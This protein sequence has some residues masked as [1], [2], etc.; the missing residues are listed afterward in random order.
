MKHLFLLS[1]ALAYCASGSC[2]TLQPIPKATPPP[3]SAKGPITLDVVV[4]NKAGH[5]I[6]GLQKQDFTL[7]DNR[8]P[9]PILSFKA[10]QA[11]N[12]QQNPT[13]IV[14]VV[15][16]VNAKFSAVSI[17]RIQI[18]SFLRKYQGKLPAP[19]SVAYL[20]ETGFEQVVPPSTDGNL[21]AAKLDQR[22]AGLRDVN[23]SA[24]FY[25]GAERLQI[26]INALTQLIQDEGTVPG[27]KIVIWMSPGWWLF[28]SPNLLIT[29]Q[30]HE[31]FFNLAVKLSTSMR[32]SRV[33]LYEVDPRGLEE[34]GGYRTFLWKDYVKPVRTP[35]QAQPGSVDLEVLSVQSGGKVLDMSNDIA[36]EIAQCVQDATAWYTL[37]FNPAPAKN[38]I[39]WHD[40][41]LKVDKPK[42]VVRTR[43][44]YYSQPD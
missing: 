21:I 15:D 38:D 40:L 8:L 1:A 24:G 25:G 2:Q 4:S 16:D 13:S 39:A 18:D 7:L 36:G 6:A 23:R 14:L 9:T 12:P 44:G 28:D 3:L 26:S 41:Q 20:T 32:Q 17:A 19:L 35:E 10:H 11:T 31:M 29:N 22:Q 33:V 5:P 43:N 37:T 34:I 30:Q 42:V 27:R